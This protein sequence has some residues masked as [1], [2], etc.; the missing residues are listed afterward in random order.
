M[1]NHWYAIKHKVGTKS[2]WMGP[3]LVT[4]RGN[5]VYWSGGP[6]YMPV[7]DWENVQIV[8]DY[9][10]ID[11]MDEDKIDDLFDQFTLDFPPE[12]ELKLSGG[13][14]APDGKLYPCRFMEHLNHA[15][16][17]AFV[18]YQERG[19][20][21]QRLEKE[22]WA[23]LYSDGVCLLPASYMYNR[24]GEYTQAQLDTL[25][26]LFVL[27][28]NEEDEVYAEHIKNEIDSRS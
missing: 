4:I 8:K 26:D 12:A 5:N 10:E 17:L 16:E 27:A 19:D 3:S 20:G 23:K 13:W 2:L 24:D 7:H 25:G 11:D 6:S 28:T 15:Q 1:T 18:H 9:G 21:A 22:G 14:L